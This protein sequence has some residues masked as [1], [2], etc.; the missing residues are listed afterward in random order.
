[1]TTLDALS[2]LYRKTEAVLKE[3]KELI[4]ELTGIAQEQQL[5]EAEV[6][7][8][9]AGKYSSFSL[10]K[11]GE[12]V[13]LT[14]TRVSDGVSMSFPFTRPEIVDIYN[15]TC[16]YFFQ[17]VYDMHIQDRQ[18]VEKRHLVKLR[19]LQDVNTAIAQLLA[20]NTTQA[21]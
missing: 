11:G 9:Q 21:P 1:M 2:Q 4:E 12:G 16:A 15:D 8:Q 6:A 19:S 5:V 7:L 14:A 10:K 3:S 13:P 20:D 18:E 17:R